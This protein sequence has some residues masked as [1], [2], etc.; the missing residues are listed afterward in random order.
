MIGIRPDLATQAF[1]SNAKL[2][3]D[4]FVWCMACC[5]NSVYFF[6]VAKSFSEFNQSIY[7]LSLSILSA[8][9]FGIFVV[10]EVK[11][12]FKFFENLETL[13]NPSE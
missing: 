12:L 9:G 7:F 1:P 3:L 11:N 5:L 4:V 10:F 8:I 6:R 13:I 2:L